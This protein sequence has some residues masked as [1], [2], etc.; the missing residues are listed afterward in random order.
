MLNDKCQVNQLNNLHTFTKYLLLN[1]TT[2]NI[3]SAII[4][5][6]LNGH[7]SLCY[8]LILFVDDIFSPFL[9]WL[10]NV[11]SSICNFMLLLKNGFV[12]QLFF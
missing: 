7:Y 12:L 9:F 2:F 3:Y 1:T 8:L 5:T 10:I 4:G 11:F 6:K